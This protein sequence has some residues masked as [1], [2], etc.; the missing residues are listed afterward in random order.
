MSEIKSLHVA[1]VLNALRELNE[2]ADWSDIIDRVTEN[3]GGGF[4]PYLDWNN[5]KKTLFQLI[6]QHCDGYKKFKGTIHFVKVRKGRFRL[7]KPK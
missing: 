1:D 4:A 5:F 6:Q 3:R 7:V 2:E